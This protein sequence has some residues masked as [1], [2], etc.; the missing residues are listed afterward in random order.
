MKT[1]IEREL[2]IDEIV[3]VPEWLDEHVMLQGGL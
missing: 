1:W 3:H 2:V